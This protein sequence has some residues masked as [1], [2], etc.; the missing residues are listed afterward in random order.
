[1]SINANRHSDLPRDIQFDSEKGVDFV[2]NYTKAYVLCLVH[3]E[4]FR[5]FPCCHDNIHLF[6][7]LER[8][9]LSHAIF[10]IRPSALVQSKGPR[11]DRAVKICLINVRPHFVSAS[12]L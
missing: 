3:F 7:E 11:R 2:L 10:E 4:T 1:M 9:S 12:G 5:A 6:S 8:L